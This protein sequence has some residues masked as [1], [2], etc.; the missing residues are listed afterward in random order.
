M[1]NKN[2]PLSP[3]KNDLEVCL[4]EHLVYRMLQAIVLGLF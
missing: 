2:N 4:V 1:F 3:H